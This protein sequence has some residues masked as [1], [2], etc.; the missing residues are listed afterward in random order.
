MND[1]AALEHFRKI[2][3]QLEAIATEQ[4]R[5]DDELAAHDAAVNSATAKIEGRV[6]ELERQALQ[7]DGRTLHV[8][9][10]GGRPVREFVIRYADGGEVVRKPDDEVAS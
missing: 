6:T 5:R 4:K 1:D 7:G 2:E 10:D 3:D 8:R 9:V